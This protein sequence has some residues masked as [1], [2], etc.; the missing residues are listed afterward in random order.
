MID[1]VVISNSVHLCFTH[2][3]HAILAHHKNCYIVS[4]NNDLFD[5]LLILH[6]MTASCVVCYVRHTC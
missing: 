3:Y 1:R 5:N 2:L 6:N 4:T